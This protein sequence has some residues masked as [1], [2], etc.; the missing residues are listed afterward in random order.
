MNTEDMYDIRKYN[1][2]E[3]DRKEMYLKDEKGQRVAKVV[4]QGSEVKVVNITYKL[5]TW[6][7]VVLALAGIAAVLFFVWMFVMALFQRPGQPFS[8]REAFELTKYFISK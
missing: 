4:V 5:K 6:V 2:I 8:F 1:G 7:N 3:E